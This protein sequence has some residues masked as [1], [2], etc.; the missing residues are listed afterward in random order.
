M[1][2]RVKICVIFEY[3]LNLPAI[4]FYCTY[5]IQ[6]TQTPF[7]PSMSSSVYSHNETLPVLTVINYRSLNDCK[8]YTCSKRINSYLNTK[9]ILF[10]LAYLNPEGV[11]P[12]YF[13]FIIMIVKVI[14]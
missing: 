13:N 12:I 14:N 10:N 5:S 1:S 7:H 3:P 4:I 2:T 11:P 8:I 6:I 9:R